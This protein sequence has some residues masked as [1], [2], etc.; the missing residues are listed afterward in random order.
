[1]LTQTEALLLSRVHNLE[2]ALTA[3]CA[4]I[5]DT[6]PPAYAENVNDMMGQFF[7]NSAKIGAFE[8]DD[9]KSS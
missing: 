1:M 2:I 5:T 4:L 8:I 3:L 6:L 9:F 7:D